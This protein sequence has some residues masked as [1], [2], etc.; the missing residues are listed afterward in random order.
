M[1]NALPHCRTDQT[2]GVWSSCL[3][4]VPPPL[5]LVGSCR[6]LFSQLSASNQPVSKSKSL[7][8]KKLSNESTQTTNTQINTRVFSQQHGHLKLDIRKPSSVVS[9]S[10]VKT[11]TLFYPN[12][13]LSIR[14]FFQFSFLTTSTCWY[15]ELVSLTQEQNVRHR[16]REAT[17]QVRVR[18]P[19]LDLRTWNQQMIFFCQKLLINCQNSC[20][21]IFFQLI[22]QPILQSTL[23]THNT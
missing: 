16:R 15:T 8:K 13:S 12:N 3:W 19:A 2:E 4:C 14:R 23:L 22:N 10:G 6:L 20:Q 17:R 21:L 18:S 11:L 1:G 9:I 7:K 5:A